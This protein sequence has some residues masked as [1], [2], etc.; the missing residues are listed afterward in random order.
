[1]F[2]THRAPTISRAPPPKPY[3]PN[4]WFESRSVHSTRAPS[5]SKRWCSSWAERRWNG[6]HSTEVKSHCGFDT[7]ARDLFLRRDPP[8]RSALLSRD[9]SGRAHTH[10]R[11]PLVGRRSLTPKERVQI[12]FSN[13]RALPP[14]SRDPIS[15][16]PA[17]KTL[18][19]SNA[20]STPAASTTPRRSLTGKG[21]SLEWKQPSRS[22][23]SGVSLFARAARLLQA[24]TPPFPAPTR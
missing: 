17:T 20:G 10:R 23:Y 24:A 12:P 8:R 2:R 11:C 22:S 14:R 9:P 6:T 5:P 18:H 4:T 3:T 19:A 15:S 7:R 13:P 1:M 21:A 16:R